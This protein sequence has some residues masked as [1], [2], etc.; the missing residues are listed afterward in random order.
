[1]NRE[2]KEPTL[3]DRL[4]GPSGRQVGCDECFELLDQY[5]E[6]DLAGEDAAELMPRV[7]THLLGCPVCMDEFESLSELVRSED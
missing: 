3:V 7:H 1:M 6:L 4:L 5:V 2:E